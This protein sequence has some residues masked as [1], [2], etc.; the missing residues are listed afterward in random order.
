VLPIAA[1]RLK[2]YAYQNGDATVSAAVATI[3]AAIDTVALADSA[4]AAHS[5]DAADGNESDK[6]RFPIS[7]DLVHLTGDGV[8]EQGWE[9]WDTLASID[10]SCANVEG[11]APSSSGSSSIEAVS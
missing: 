7:S 4:Y 1:S 10:Q 6:D 11:A 3:N 9:L 2:T 5:L 8:I